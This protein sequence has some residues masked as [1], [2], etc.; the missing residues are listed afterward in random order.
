[1]DHVARVNRIKAEGEAHYHV[2]SRVANQ[3]FLFRADR[4]KDTV[5]NMLHRA[6]EFSGV[7]VLSYVVMDN[8]F[9]LCIRVPEKGIVSEDEVLRRVG[10]LRLVKFFDFFL[11][12]G[13]WHLIGKRRCGVPQVGCIKTLALRCGTIRARKTNNDIC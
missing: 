5:V 7:D 13:A 10:L 12:Y 3:A 8:H 4:I 1:M 6:A 11:E 9:H 2:I